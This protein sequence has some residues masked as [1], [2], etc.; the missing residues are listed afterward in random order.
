MPVLPLVGSMMTEP[1]L[2]TPLSSRYSIIAMPSRSLTEASGLK[3]SSLPMIS[4][5]TFS[6][7]ASLREPHQRRRADGLQQIVIDAAAEVRA[8]RMT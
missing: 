7:L 6:A 3:N 1:G 2:S 5:L 4:A 8:V